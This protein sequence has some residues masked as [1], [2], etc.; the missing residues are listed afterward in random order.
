MSI[1]TSSPMLYQAFSSQAEIDAQYNPSLALA[2][3][4][5]PGKHYAAQSQLARS[6]LRCALDVPY[7]ATLAETLDIFPADQPNAPV[8]VFIHGGYWR[9]LTSKEFSGVALGLVPRG[10]TTVVINHALCPWVTID[11]IV[12]QCRAAVAWV[13]RHISQH[14][15]DP[16][17]VALAGHSAGGHLTAMCLQ[18]EWARDYGLSQDPL[19]GALLFSGLYDLMPL[20]YSYLQP[21]IQLDDGIVRRNSPAFAVRPSATPVWV[22]WG[23]QE[24]AE[25]ARQSALYHQAWAAAGNRGTL[26][27]VAGAN[28]FSVIQGLE[29]PASPLCDWIVAA[30]KTAVSSAAASRLPLCKP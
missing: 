21:A 8:L 4:S 16:E 1:P 20:R 25:F 14:G 26:A 7:G 23:D 9:A 12:R 24:T 29:D 3:V 18:T 19:A 10:V 27:P 22:T 5:A 17:R 6:T 2:D 15:G 30:L 28:H 11:E 13:K